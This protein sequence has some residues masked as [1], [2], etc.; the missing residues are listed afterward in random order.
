LIVLVALG[1]WQWQRMHWKEG[2]LAQ[3]AER[4]VADPAP[5]ADVLSRVQSSSADREYTRVFV[6]GVFDHAHEKHVYASGREGAGW[7]IFTPL[8]DAS[9]VRVAWVNRGFVPHRLKAPSSRPESQP[10]GQIEL[11]GLF[12]TEPSRSFFAPENAPKANIWYARDISQMHRSAFPETDTSF[13][14]DWYVDADRSG[15]GWPRGGT[16]NL[17]LSNRHLSY[18][19]TWWG[20][21]ATLLGVFAV[22]AVQRFRAAR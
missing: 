8:L 5:L 11:I 2:L 14:P 6:K 12:R 4:T 1:N 3:I 10:S 22:F 19:L 20:L 16:T 15:E 9:G 21:A 13:V 7:L 17:K 18:A